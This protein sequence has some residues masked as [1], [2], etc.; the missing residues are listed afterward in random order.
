MTDAKLIKTTLSE[1]DLNELKMIFF[2][3]LQQRG[4]G[5]KFYNNLGQKNPKLH[6]IFAQTHK[7][8][9]GH[10]IIEAFLMVID[11]RKNQCNWAKDIHH[12]ASL[13]K[14]IHIADEYYDFLVASLNEALN[15]YQELSKLLTGKDFPINN[16]N[17]LLNDILV[18]F[19]K[20]INTKVTDSDFTTK[21]IEELIS[22]FNVITV[23]PFNFGEN[24]YGKFVSFD[25]DLDKLFSSSHRS[26]LG[27]VMLQLFITILSRIQKGEEWVS[28]IKDLSAYHTQYEIKNEYYDWLY[29]SF[30]ETMNQYYHILPKKEM[31]NLRLI[32]AIFIDVLFIFRR[33]MTRIKYPLIEIISTTNKN[34]TK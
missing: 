18:E 22:F 34:N 19:K 30:M 16:F 20:G 23:H 29:Q 28:I 11:K 33:E 31:V 13:H 10:Q 14:H 12:I 15:T 27:V 17:I 32:E 25:Q 24:F 6:N 1:D 4:F 7:N 2:K 3:I 21:D 9:L 5:E 8:N 26:N